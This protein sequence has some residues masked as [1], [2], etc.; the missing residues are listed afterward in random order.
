MVTR[1]DAG[2]VLSALDWRD[3]V[4]VLAPD[5]IRVAAIDRL[6]GVTP[7]MIDW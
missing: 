4:R 1:D 7:E 2:Q 6:G 5:R 3:E